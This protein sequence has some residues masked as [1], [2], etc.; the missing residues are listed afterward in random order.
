MWTHFLQDK[1]MLSREAAAAPEPS[2]P[3][4]LALI[5]DQDERIEMVRGGFFWKLD[6]NVNLPLFFK[7]SLN[8]N[9]EW[10]PFGVFGEVE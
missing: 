6:V 7:L 5:F 4:K 10:V 9:N 2:Q 1:V 3:P 8:F